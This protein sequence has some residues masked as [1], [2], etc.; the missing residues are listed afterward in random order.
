MFL[1]EQYVNQY[2]V[3]GK[4][5][6]VLADFSTF[7]LKSAIHW[8][9]WSGT[10]F[11]DHLFT[12]YS[13]T[14]DQLQ[15]GLYP[16]TLKGIKKPAP[17]WQQGDFIK[18]MRFIV[19][20]A[21]QGFVTEMDLIREIGARKLLSLVY[22]NFLHRRP[23]PNYTFDIVNPPNVPI[24]TPMSQPALRVMEELLKEIDGEA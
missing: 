24:L 11:I 8:F 5:E 15:T 4:F 19:K 16:E 13:S 3:Q 10:W 9:W 1:S 7:P 12:Y 14:Y 21:D 23:T 6:G 18:A 2:S 17:A 20:N 22:Y